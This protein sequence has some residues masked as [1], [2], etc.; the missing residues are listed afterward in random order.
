MAKWKKS[1]ESKANKLLKD[2]FLTY[3]KT[4]DGRVSQ[5]LG[6]EILEVTLFDL[7][8]IN[9]KCRET[10]FRIFKNALRIT[11]NG[12]Y[13]DLNTLLQNFISLRKQNSSRTQSFVYVGTLTII[14]PNNFHSFKLNNCFIRFHSNLPVKYRLSREDLLQTYDSAFK[15]DPNQVFFTV[16]LT[17]SDIS[18][19][20]QV[21]EDSIALFR[22]LIQLD[23]KKNQRIFG[24]T[25]EESYPSISFINQGRYRTLHNLDG[26]LAADDTVWFD[27][28]H[29][30][31]QVKKIAN[32]EITKENLTK[33]LK[34]LK[35]CTFKSHME[36]ALI[37]YITALDTLEPT[38]R[39]VSLFSTLEILLREDTTKGL[40]RKIGSIYS[41]WQTIA[42]ILENLRENRNDYIHKGVLPEKTSLKTQHLLFIVDDVMKFFLANNFKFN[43][44]DH[45]LSFLELP[46]FEKDIKLQLELLKLRHK[47]SV[48]LNHV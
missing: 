40:L 38:T 14:K 31:S 10:D 48:T 5:T 32:P 43:N 35:K 47:Y 34:M 22:A 12:R 30:E 42:P 24:R 7:L 36:K 15:E 19:A 4:S 3:R 44:V 1:S 17:A 9:D 37:S 16:S 25:Q 13:R 20:S 28:A 11:F 21:A 18:T 45:L 39:F 26:T 33:R 41:N 8:S 27:E 6:F 23:L 2:I 46:K 29:Y